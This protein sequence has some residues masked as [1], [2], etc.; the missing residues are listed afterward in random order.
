MI[1]DIEHF[2]IMAT[3]LRSRGYCSHF[4]QVWVSVLHRLFL[5]CDE[6]HDCHLVPSM[7]RADLSLTKNM[8]SGFPRYFLELRSRKLSN[9]E[10]QNHKFNPM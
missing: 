2:S 6:L 1:S 7:E 4:L 9:W 10:Y 8:A 3:I 5:A